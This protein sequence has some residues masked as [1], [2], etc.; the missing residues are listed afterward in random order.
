LLR[1]NG[2]RELPEQ[3]AQETLSAALLNWGHFRSRIAGKK[4]LERGNNYNLE[5]ALDCSI[6]CSS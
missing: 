4:Q 1:R 5:S 2:W 6:I 3:F